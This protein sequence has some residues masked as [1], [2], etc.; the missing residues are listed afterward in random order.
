MGDAGLMDDVLRE[1]LVESHECLDVLQRTLTA[2]EAQP[3]SR[4]DLASMFRAVHTIKG[5]CG[6]LGFA[7]LESITRVGEGLLGRLRDGEVR[8]TPEVTSAILTMANTIRC[9]LGV[10]EAEGRDGDADHSAL[11]DILARLQM[12]A[13]ASD[14]VQLD[15]A[16]STR[17]RE[18]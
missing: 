17:V 13:A 18:P 2:L 16:G 7:K 11:I 12:P 1:F 5:A 8:L 9:V 10:I 15:P 3:T 6:F 4:E 14:G